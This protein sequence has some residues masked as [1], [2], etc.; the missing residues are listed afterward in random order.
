MFSE[1]LGYF[2]HADERVLGILIRD[3]T[4]DDYAGA[5]L[6]RDELHQYRWIKGTSFQ[7]T[8]RHAKALLRRELELT[9]MQ[10]ED[11]YHQGHNRPKLVDFFTPVVKV[12]LLNTSFR[13]LIEAEQ[14]SSARGIIEPMMRWYQDVDGNFIEQFQTTGFDARVWE[15]YFFAM[16]TELNFRIDRTEPAPDFL[17]ESSFGKI[18]IEAVTVN[19]TEKGVGTIGDPPDLNTDEGRSAYRNEYMPIKF[20]SALYSKLRKRYW[21]KKHACGI[22]LVLAVQDFS[23]PG[24]MTYTGS[25]LGVYLYGYDHDPSRDD[26]GRLIVTPRRVT[27]HRWGEK[28]IPSGF[29]F[30]PEAENISAVLAN[31]SGTLSKFNRIG[32]MAGFGSTR[33]RMI[34]RGVAIDLDPDASEPVRFEYDVGSSGYRETWVEGCTIFHNPL[35]LVP[36]DPDLIPGATHLRLREDGQIVPIARPS[37]HPLGS[38]TVLG[39]PGEPPSEAEGE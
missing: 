8:P 9:A 19:P 17:A 25:A 13:R 18:A 21:A 16:L 23:L 37:F 20:G 27:T 12:D 2:E 11:T 39:V 7:P 36:L 35:A 24:S 31:F 26:E 28:E 15:L 33:V 4:D 5:V 29:F 34:R 32:R 6:A 3:R 14:F 10:S 38:W 1:E 22:P 30:Q